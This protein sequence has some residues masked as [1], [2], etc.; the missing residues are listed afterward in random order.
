[1]FLR[2]TSSTDT[3]DKFAVLAQRVSGVIH[4]FRR[5]V[6]GVLDRL[7]HLGAAG[8]ADPGRDV[9]GRQAVLVQEVADVVADSTFRRP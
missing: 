6:E 3:D 7:D 2:S 1:M 8:V 5:Q 4:G 9:I